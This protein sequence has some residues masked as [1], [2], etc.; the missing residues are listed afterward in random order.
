MGS[1]RW[2]IIFGFWWL[3]ALSRHLQTQ[4][5]KATFLSYLFHPPNQKTSTYKCNYFRVKVYLIAS[6]AH[7]TYF[8]H[9]IPAHCDHSPFRMFLS[10]YV[11]LDGGR[12]AAVLQEVRGHHHQQRQISVVSRRPEV[13]AGGSPPGEEA[14]ATQGA[15]DHSPPGRPSSVEDGGSRGMHA[16]IGISDFLCAFRRIHFLVKRQQYKV[17]RRVAFATF[18]GSG[19]GNKGNWLSSLRRRWHVVCVW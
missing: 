9:D 16:W 3:A 6:Y 18:I 17:V 15:G 14:G 7:V 11:G 4:W 13:P 19:G 10:P 2:G 12:G 1:G 8:S 5:K